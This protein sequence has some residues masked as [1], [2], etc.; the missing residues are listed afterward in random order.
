MRKLLT[1]IIALLL[2][3]LPKDTRAQSITP[4]IG[5]GISFGADGG[6][7]GTGKQ[8]PQPTGKLLM[9]DGVSYLLLADGVSK[10]CLAGGCGGGG[11][12]DAAAT[13]AF[14][15][16][17]DAIT[18][19]GSAERAAYK[20]LINGLVTDGNLALLDALYIFATD[21]AAHANLNIVQNAFNL[22][23]SGS[24]TFT[25]DAGYTGDGTT[26]YFD[27]GFN[28][29]TAGG[30][31]SLSSASLGTYILFNR[32][33]P[34]TSVPIGAVTGSNYTLIQPLASG[35][36]FTGDINSIT[37]PSVANSG[38][39]AAWII[40][41]PVSGGSTTL[42]AYKNGSSTPI[43]STADSSSGLPNAT[44]FILALNSSGT[45]VD[46]GSDQK[47]ATFFGGGLTGTQAAAI[48]NRINA[49]MT[50]FGVNVY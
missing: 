27:T 32:T 39:K 24:V 14:L 20:T 21:T 37:F 11:G 15:A 19:V 36:V 10:I 17:A 2:V 6:I 13:T 16:R 30:N 9:A 26:G 1:L 33:T 29:S 7:S 3:A 40:T 41:R 35:P 12:G 46:F 18:T 8:I 25:I 43:F 49:F 5:G 44:L 38:T 45:Q 34:S 28:P 4:Q 31:F 22:T 23:Q 42:N 47:G 50:A 48:N